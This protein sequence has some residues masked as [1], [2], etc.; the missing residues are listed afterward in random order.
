LSSTCTTISCQAAPLLSWASSQ[1]GA[2]THLQLDNNLLLGS[3]PAELG[4]LGALTHLYLDGNQLSGME[5]FQS[6]MKEH[7]AG[8][9]LLL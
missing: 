6:H 1:L 5:A 4:Q 9:E 2:L 8:C 7:H 3:I